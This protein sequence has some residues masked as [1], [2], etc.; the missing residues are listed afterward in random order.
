MGG[1]R[2][3]RRK[4]ARKTIRPMD[5]ILFRRILWIVT[6]T[7]LLVALLIKLVLVAGFAAPFLWLLSPLFIGG[8]IAFILCRPQRF[9]EKKLCPVL[10]QRAAFLAKPFSIAGVYLLLGGVVFAIVAFLLPQLMDSVRM[11]YSNIALYTEQFQRLLN[12]VLAF[13]HL[14]NIKIDQL[15]E[16]LSEL[17]KL[18]G[19]A[20][21]G[22]LPQ[23]LDA[24]GSVVRSVANTVLGFVISVYLLADREK[25]GRQGADLINAYLP[26]RT[27]QGLFR[28]LRISNRTFS[29]FVTGQLTEALILGCMCFAG[30]LIFGFDYPLLISTMIGV[31]SLIPI[32]GAII[33][34]VPA[35]FLLLMI[36]PVKAFWFIVFIL[37]LQQIEGDFIYPRVV[38]SSIG[39]PAVWILLTVV[40][41]GGIG[42][43]LGMLIGV[44]IASVLY[45]LLLTDV[46]RRLNRT[47]TPPADRS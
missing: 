42:G 18:A 35:V 22:M 43:V 36:D 19:E 41:G 25:L 46:D 38:G 8:A 17:P 33:G 39:L 13:L 29:N 9:L 27:A 12:E 14:N 47:E 45:Q 40:I 11:L 24:T 37:V 6:Y 16:S 3:L 10:P 7:I 23:V 30:M 32:A 5:K 44:P 31:T 4:G 26:A 21:F 20:L 28:V 34:C 2:M 15:F 1:N